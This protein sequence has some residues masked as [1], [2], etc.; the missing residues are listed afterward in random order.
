M[1]NWCLQSVLHGRN[2]TEILVRYKLNQNYSLRNICNAL[3]RRGEG[4]GLSLSLS[5]GINVGSEVFTGVLIC[6]STR[7]I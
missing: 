5:S 3:T 2:G 7:L 1:K 4:T 6:T